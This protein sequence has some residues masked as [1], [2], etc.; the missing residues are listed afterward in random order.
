MSI[1]HAKVST[2]PPVSDPGIIDSADWNDDHDLSDM[3][4][5]DVPGLTDALDAAS[6]MVSPIKAAE[7]SVTTTATLTLD[8]MH[9]CSGT[10]A[11]Y[12]VTL[13]AASGNAGRLVGVRMAAGLTR[14]VTLKGNGSEL[15]DGSNTRKMWARESAVLICDGTT[16]TKIAGRNVAIKTVMYRSNANGAWAAAVT[17]W[18]HVPTPSVVEDNT[19]ALAV[20]AADTTNA[21]IRVLRTSVYS[22]KGYCSFTGIAATKNMAIGVTN[23]AIGVVGFTP[24]EPG[25][26][27]QRPDDATNLYGSASIDKTATDGTI[28][29]LTIYNGDTATRN[30]RSGD[31]INPTVSLLELP[32]W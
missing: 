23:Q 31:S 19:S 13:P 15:I 10:S 29:G 8:R 16:W 3:E 21:R 32:T 28:V 9:V 30:T 20:P 18:F 6:G 5:A 27:Y 12:T 22:L 25:W 14:W 4:L 26:T 2:Q 7:I 11:D 24:Q 17:G 1:K